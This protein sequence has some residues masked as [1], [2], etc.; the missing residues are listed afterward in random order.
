MHQSSLIL[1]WTFRWLPK[2]DFVLISRPTPTRFLSN[3]R[4]LQAQLAQNSATNKPQVERFVS[5]AAERL[6]QRTARTSVVTLAAG[7]LAVADFS[8]HIT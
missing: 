8:L 5:F 1:A 6:R 4:Q 2:F 3:C 7:K